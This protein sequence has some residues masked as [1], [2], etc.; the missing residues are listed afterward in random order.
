VAGEGVGGLVEE[1]EAVALVAEA[2]VAAALLLER[3]DPG[4]DQFFHRRP[5]RPLSSRPACASGSASSARRNPRSCPAQ[6][7]RNRGARAA[8]SFASASALS[9][10]YAIT[11]TS[12]GS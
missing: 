11:L 1:G 12:I 8:S 4:S 3:E 9:V 5:T 2:G 10:L 7:Q 6:P